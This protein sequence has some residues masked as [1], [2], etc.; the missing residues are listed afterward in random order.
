MPRKQLKDCRDQNT[1]SI[2]S[3]LENL[4]YAYRMKWPRYHNDAHV[5]C[6]IILANR[7]SAG[8]GLDRPEKPWELIP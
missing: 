5:W 7:A 4:R 3:S 1:G 2:T 6:N 8:V